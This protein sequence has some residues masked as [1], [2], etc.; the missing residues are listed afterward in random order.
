MSLPPP[1]DSGD[2]ARFLSAL[3]E[4][5]LVTFAREIAALAQAAAEGKEDVDIALAHLLAT[6][7]NG[8]RAEIVK[9]FRA[10]VEELHT[11]REAAEE[12]AP[13]MDEAARQ[14]AEAHERSRFALWLSEKTLEKIR[15]AFL[16]NPLLLRQ[17]IDLGQD[18]FGKGVFAAPPEQ[19]KSPQETLAPP[20]VKATGHRKE[21]DRERN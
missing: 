21:S 14:Q 10:I 2:E 13:L 5:I 7:L 15:R 17:T 9:R 11:S 19:R 3:E 6:A 1:S 20:P 8:V 18:L 12:R 4:D 16:L